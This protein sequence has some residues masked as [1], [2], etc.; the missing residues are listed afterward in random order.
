MPAFLARFLAVAA[1]LAPLA[2]SAQ[3]FPATP[4]RIVIAFTAGGPNDLVM[5]PLAQ[6]LQELL[7][8]PFV[9]DYRPGANGTIGT[10][11]VAKSAADGYTLLAMSSSFPV[12][13]AVSAR[14]PFDLVH[15]F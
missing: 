3:E 2:A 7:G 1:L 10:D 8:Q 4:V 12:N 5:R 15:D 11:H 9:I 14:L 6:K 13:S